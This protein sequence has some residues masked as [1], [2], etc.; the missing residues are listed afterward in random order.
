MVL[1]WIAV[2]PSLGGA[3]A[4]PLGQTTLCRFVASVGSATEGGLNLVPSALQHCQLIPGSACL[5]PAGSL[6]PINWHAW[7]LNI[8]DARSSMNP[9]SLD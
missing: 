6:V 9:V 7:K 5:T 4:M 8:L 2:N 3:R 1:S